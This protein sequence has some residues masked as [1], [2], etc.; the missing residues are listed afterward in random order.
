MDFFFNN[1]VII[2][3]IIIDFNMRINKDIIPVNCLYKQYTMNNA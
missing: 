1:L 2:K 3:F